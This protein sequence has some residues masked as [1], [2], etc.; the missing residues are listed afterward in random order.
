MKGGLTI[1]VP[2]LD[3]TIRA[4]ETRAESAKTTGLD[5]YLEG[6]A[7]FARKALSDPVEIREV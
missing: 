3:L 1:V 5:Q 7:R 6:I 4:K 2:D